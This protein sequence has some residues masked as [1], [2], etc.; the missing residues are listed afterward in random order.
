MRTL[1]L[2]KPRVKVGGRP[3]EIV[4]PKSLQ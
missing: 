4:L 3:K 2:P 1:R